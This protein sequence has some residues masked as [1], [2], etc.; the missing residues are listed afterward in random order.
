MEREKNIK[1]IS[2]VIDKK[3]AKKIEESVYIFSKEYTETNETPFLL[4]S[5]YNDKFT[6]IYNLLINTKSCFLIDALN[7]NKI[8]PL[9]IA[10]M[11]PDE[12]NPDKYE[13]ILK[14][15][16]LE[17]F[18]K[19]NQATSSIYKCPKCKEKKCTIIQKQ[20]RSADEPATL[21]IDCKS[22][23]YSHVHDDS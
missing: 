22:C 6:E 16:E 17:E 11:R 13:K 23:G 5:I 14:K 10:F 7:E 9:K 20:T 1:K 21:Y 18:K 12:L 19:S 4:D 2:E 8:D 15:K 3:I